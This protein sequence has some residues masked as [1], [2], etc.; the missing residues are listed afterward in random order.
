MTVEYDPN[1]G[2]I[3]TAFRIKSTV[4]VQVLAKA[5]FWILLVSHLFISASYKLEYYSPE[6]FHLELAM[7]LTGITGSLM[8]FF[9]VF[10]NGN[11][12]ARY[13]KLYELTK[14][15]NEFCL[16]AVSIITR[17]IT[18]KNLQRKLSRMLLASAFLF[19]FERTQSSDDGNISKAE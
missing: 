4:V 8:T 2:I 9:V 1:A 13:N 12:F 11:V 16:Y 10:Y 18:D 5:E 19:F 6:S 17:E 14:N 7:G 3:C 15:M